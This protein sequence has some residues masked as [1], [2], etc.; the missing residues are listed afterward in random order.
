MK[1]YVLFFIIFICLAETISCTNTK[2]EDDAL[3]KI[4]KYDK[5]IN[6]DIYDYQKD[7][8]EW[9]VPETEYIS[10]FD[11]DNPDRIIRTFEDKFVIE[12]D[13]LYFILKRQN[14]DMWAYV[15]LLTGEMFDLCPDPLCPHTEESGCKYLNLHDLVFVPGSDNLIY[16]VKTVDAGNGITYNAVCLLNTE[17]DTLHELYASDIDKSNV[18]N[19]YDLCFIT[20]EYLY[21]SNIRI[22][23]IRAENGEIE[24]KAE[25]NLMTL[26]LVTNEVKEI[27]NKYSSQEYGKYFYADERHIFFIDY[28][29]KNFYAT[30]LNFE[31]EQTILEYGQEY[32]IRNFYYDEGTSE[33]FI[34]LY[35]DYLFGYS[36][37]ETEEGSVYCVNSDLECRKLDMPSEKIINFQLTNKYIYYAVYA[38]V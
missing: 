16:T 34:G 38:P 3:L 29:N 32:N 5:T 17:N 36:D 22:T 14:Q 26:N 9:L 33:F 2:S 1:K 35:A 37:N 11:I 25:E 30:D 18:I 6:A 27:N 10:C 8:A 31:N 12:E 24:Q 15:S 23:S 21:F 4:Q 7:L 20:D 13:R 19:I 28:N